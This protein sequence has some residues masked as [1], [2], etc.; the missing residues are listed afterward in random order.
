M[1]RGK[2]GISQSKKDKQPLGIKSKKEDK[3][4]KKDF[5]R[6]LKEINEV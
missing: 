5:I 6:Y 4:P 2:T 3:L 1:E